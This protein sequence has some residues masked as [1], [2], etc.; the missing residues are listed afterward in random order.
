MPYDPFTNKNVPSKPIKQ[1]MGGS[2]TRNGVD[3]SKE[4]EKQTAAKHKAS[5]KKHEMA[6]K[7]GSSSK[8][9]ELNFTS[10]R[11]SEPTAADFKKHFP[12]DRTGG[13]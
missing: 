8:D 4:I 11:K 2:V 1:Q 9:S 13:K 6:K 10:W 7:I 3:V 12:S 5:A